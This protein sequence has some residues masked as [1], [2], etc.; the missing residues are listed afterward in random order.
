MKLISWIWTDEKQGGEFSGTILTERIIFVVLLVY[1]VAMIVLASQG[2]LQ[3]VH[4][5]LGQFIAYV[6][7]MAKG[8]YQAKRVI[9]SYRHRQSGNDLMN[10]MMY[11]MNAMQN[12]GSQDPEAEPELLGSRGRGNGVRRRRYQS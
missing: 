10:Q 12:Q 5:D 9:E 8:A 4:I 6:W 11:S 3:P 1:I 7:L 2:W